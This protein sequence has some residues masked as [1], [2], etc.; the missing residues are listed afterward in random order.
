[1]NWRTMVDATT[2][3]NGHWLVAGIVDVSVVAWK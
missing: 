3:G 1:M 2:E